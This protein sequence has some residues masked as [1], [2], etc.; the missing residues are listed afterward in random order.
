[1]TGVFGHG[2]EGNVDKRVRARFFPG[3]NPGVLVEVG[4]A[5]PE[6]LSVSAMY[7]DLGWRVI[8]VEPNPEFCEL[9]RARG[10][11]ILQYACGDHD[12]EDVDFCIVDSRGAAYRDGSVTYESFSSLAIKDAYANLAES[13]LEIRWIKVNL[14]RLDTLLKEHAAALEQ[15][16][17]LAVDVEGWELEVLDGLDFQRFRPRVLIVENLLNDPGYYEYMRS[18]GYGLWRQIE[19]NDVYVPRSELR[20]DDR[21]VRSLAR[22]LSRGRHAASFLRAGLH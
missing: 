12:E 5:H 15:I 3:D 18:R 17:I 20:V 4:A 21:M 16:D 1:M 10:H 19:P 13:D 14:R 6:Y 11:D 2:A 7:R 22:L 9:H 8:A